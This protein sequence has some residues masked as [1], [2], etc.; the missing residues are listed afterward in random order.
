MTQ[1]SAPRVRVITE[2]A[3]Q[4]VETVVQTDNR[5]AVRFDMLRSRKGWPAMKDAP[6]LWMTVLAWSAMRREQATDLDVEAFLEAALQV[7]PV[8][9][10]GDAVGPG[11]G[12]QAAVPFD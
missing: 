7:Q 5:D 11:D 10:A 1:L 4:Y 12:S 6:M 9:E 3:G 2:D 8:N